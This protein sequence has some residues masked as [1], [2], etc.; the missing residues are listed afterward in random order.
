MRFLVL[1]L[2][3][4]E[5]LDEVLDAWRAAGVKGITILDSSGVHRRRGEVDQQSAPMFL[6][7]SR[8]LQSDQY[9]HNTLFSVVE[10]ESIIPAVAEATERILG[11]LR[12]PHTGV[13]FTLPVDQAWGIP[14]RRDLPAAGPAPDAEEAR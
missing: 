2:D 8:M 13:M 6:G 5:K 10:D 9:I 7:L 4:P 12:D 11:D 3:N 1:V 14:K